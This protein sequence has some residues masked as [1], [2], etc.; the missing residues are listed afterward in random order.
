MGTSFLIFT[1]LVFCSGY[2]ASVLRNN[3]LFVIISVFILI[4]K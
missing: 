1:L 2:V 4:T 3:K